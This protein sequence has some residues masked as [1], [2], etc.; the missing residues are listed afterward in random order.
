MIKDW[1]IEE[2]YGYKPLTTLYTDFGIAENFGTSAIIDTYNR[3]KKE[4]K[5]DYKILTELCMVLDWKIWEHYGK[6]EDFANLYNRLWEE[7]DNNLMNNL[8]DDE[9][10]YFIQMTD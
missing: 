6:N 2:M 9:L 5:E 4:Y 3:V 10:Q 1:N 8:K 7:L